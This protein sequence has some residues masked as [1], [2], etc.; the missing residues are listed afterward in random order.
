[1]PCDGPT[2]TWRS[3]SAPVDRMMMRGRS[4]AYS[5]RRAHSVVQKG[6]QHIHRMRFASTQMNADS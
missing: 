4:G 1:M 6:Y 3:A 2:Q 5:A